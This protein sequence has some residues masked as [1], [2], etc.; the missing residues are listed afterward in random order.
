MS[1][2]YRPDCWDAHRAAGCDQDEDDARGEAVEQM[3]RSIAV[4]SATCQAMGHRWVAVWRG[5]DMTGWRCM[6][7]NER[8]EP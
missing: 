2:G 1:A 8:L 7:C 5:R 4:S 3:R 6:G